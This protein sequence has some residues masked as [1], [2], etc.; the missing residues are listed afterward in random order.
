MSTTRIGNHLLP[1]LLCIV[2]GLPTNVA[3][4]GTSL[5]SG[6]DVSMV[7]VT[8]RLHLAELLRKLLDFHLQVDFCDLVIQLLSCPVRERLF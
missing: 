7:V 1:A 3:K 2:S 5:I 6:T 4:L 8:F